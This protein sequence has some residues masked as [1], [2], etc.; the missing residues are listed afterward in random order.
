MFK[1]SKIAL[2]PELVL[3]NETARLDQKTDAESRLAIRGE[4]G[5]VF[6]K[7]VDGTTR[8]DI[9]QRVEVTGNVRGIGEEPI[10]RKQSRYAGENGQQEIKGH[11]RCDQQDAVF[12]NTVI[13]SQE[14]I[15]P[16]LG[17][18][19]RGCVGGSAATGFQL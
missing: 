9:G 6:T 5:H 10:Y 13:N 8:R 4:T 15:L 11:S 14:N 2:T 17:R 19:L 12:R 16:S 1:A 3:H 7:Q 18:N